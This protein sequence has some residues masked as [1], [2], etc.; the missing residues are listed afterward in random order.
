MK[1]KQFEGETVIVVLQILDKTK[2][3]KEW[4]KIKIE[5]IKLS[6]SIKNSPEVERI[7]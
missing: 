7:K 1:L 3:K 2:D 4:E 6:G 5:M